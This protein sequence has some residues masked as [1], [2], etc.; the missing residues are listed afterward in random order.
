MARRI[1]RDFGQGGSV[2]AEEIE[3]HRDL[4]DESALEYLDS[5]VTVIANAAT[6]SFNA[7][8]PFACEVKAI[9]FISDDPAVS[10][11]GT[12]LATVTGD[13]T[14][15]LAATDFDLETLVTG[16]EQSPALA[17]D[18]TTLTLARGDLIVVTY[19]SNNVDMTNGTDQ[20]FLMEIEKLST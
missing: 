1:P 20:G 2:N 6:V 7:R 4:H 19:T 8:V 18:V 11:S 17:T 12:V 14:N 13:G 16:V 9:R 3:L 15:L 5:T 10:S